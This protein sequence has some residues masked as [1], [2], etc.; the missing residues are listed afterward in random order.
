MFTVLSQSHASRTVA[1][2][3]ATLIVFFVG[4]SRVYLGM[5]WVTDVLGGWMLGS[6]WVAG[7]TVALAPLDTRQP[8]VTPLDT[9][10]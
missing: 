1:W 10:P 4:V 3:V 2:L 6:L 5:H 9:Q 8:R 7:L